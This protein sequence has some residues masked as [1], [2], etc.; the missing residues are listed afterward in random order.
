MRVPEDEDASK[1][2]ANAKTAFSG[3][4]LDPEEVQLK[5]YEGIVVPLVGELENFKEMSRIK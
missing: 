5:V 1:N 3:I 4:S 2:A